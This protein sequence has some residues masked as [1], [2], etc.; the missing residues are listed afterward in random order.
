MLQCILG[1]VLEKKSI[2]FFKLVFFYAQQVF[3]V[4]NNSLPPLRGQI[5]MIFIMTSH[6]HQIRN[7]VISLWVASVDERAG[8]KVTKAR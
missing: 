2:Q 3:K 4:Q 1:V 6:L 7:R 5:L 8:C